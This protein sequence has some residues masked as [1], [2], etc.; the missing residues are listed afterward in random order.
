MGLRRERELV[1]DT[2]DD[3]SSSSDG[4]SDASDEFERDVRA[5]LAATEA[6]WCE[7]LEAELRAAI[8]EWIDGAIQGLVD[9]A[10]RGSESET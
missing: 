1:D 4:V 9:E 3:V 2:V 6:E 5:A 10:G 7:V 8:G